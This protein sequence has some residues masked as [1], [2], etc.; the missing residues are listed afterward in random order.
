MV[1]KKLKDLLPEDIDKLNCE[2]CLTKRHSC[3]FYLLARCHKEDYKAM[4]NSGALLIFEL[5]K[6]EKV[7]VDIDE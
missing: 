4:L 7:E 1:K 2:D 3:P 6:D 5:N